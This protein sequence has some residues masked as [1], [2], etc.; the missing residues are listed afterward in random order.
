M[1][2]FLRLSAVVL[3][4]TSVV[5]FPAL[6]AEKTGVGAQANAPQAGG[7]SGKV[8]ETMNAASY[9]YVQ[10]DTG[11]G[12]VWAAAPQFVVKVGDTV[13]VAD[14][15][16]MMKYQ[17]KT[18]NRT[19]DVVYFSGNIAVNGAP[20]APTASGAPM[21]AAGAAPT[22]AGGLPKGHPT[23]PPAG[24]AVAPDLTNIKRAEGGQT[25]T[26]IVTGK[27]KFAGKPIAVRGRVVKFNAGILGKN[28]LH[29][30][31]GSGAEGTNDLTVTTDV[32]VKVG[33]LV[34]VTGTLASDRDFGSGY[35]YSLIVE[36]AK[37]VVQ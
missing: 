29:V 20:S 34:L 19:F 12:K 23:I 1:N 3:A 35:K 15:M 4:F 22:A 24:A 2:K 14:A 33:D 11:T 32:V 17:S 27:A 8:V 31:D 36:N 13:T 30:R 21:P 10:I 6:A 7:F 37:V 26:E 5:G 16:P 25:V 18:L 28:W 9:T